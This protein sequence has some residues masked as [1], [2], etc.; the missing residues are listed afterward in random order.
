LGAGATITNPYDFDRS[1]VVTSVDSLA[2]RFNAGTVSKIAIGNPP[3]APTAAPQAMIE[4]GLDIGGSVAGLDAV[5]S[6]LA[7][8]AIDPQASSRRFGWWESHGG[9]SVLGEA[10]SSNQGTRTSTFA[11]MAV[12]VKAADRALNVAEFQSDSSD[13]ALLDDA[14]LELLVAGRH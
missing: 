8:P 5:V 12:I 11:G 13:D 10:R 6:A 1:G 9:A 14:L 7:A 2:A 3:S 4:A